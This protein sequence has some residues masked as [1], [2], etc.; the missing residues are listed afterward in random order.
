MNQPNKTVVSLCKNDCVQYNK[1]KTG[2]NNPSITNA[3]KYSQLVRNGVVI[4]SANA[5]YPNKT[6]I[7]TSFSSKT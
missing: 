7:F 3:M 1:L 4:K 2:G 6:P 5:I